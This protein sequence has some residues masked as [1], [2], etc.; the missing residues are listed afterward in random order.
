[1]AAAQLIWQQS[2]KPIALYL[3]G[4]VTLANPKYQPWDIDYVLITD[5]IENQFDFSNLNL[6]EEID[7]VSVSPI[8]V[9]QDIILKKKLETSVLLKGDDIRT[10][11]STVINEK[12]RTQLISKQLLLLT[13][14]VEYLLTEIDLIEYKARIAAYTKSVLR[15]GGLFILSSDTPLERDPVICGEILKSRYPN[16]CN[17]IDYLQKNL[18]EAEKIDSKILYKLVQDLREII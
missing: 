8:Q 12:F 11:I 10:P 13:T 5:C 2:K 9:E 6:I 3:R 16:L 14:K 15:L 18:G 7:V 1:M 17:E 4:S